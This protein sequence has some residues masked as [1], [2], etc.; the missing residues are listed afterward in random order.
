M[1]TCAHVVE[2]ALGVH[3][4]E[5]GE[6]QVAVSLP[7]AKAG[8]MSAWWASVAS[9][10]P[11][12][13]DDVVLLEPVDNPVT[14]DKK[15]VAVLGKCEGSETNK[16]QSYGFAS[17]SP[18][19]ATY[20]YGNIM[21]PVEIDQTAKINLQVKM[22]EL[23]TEDILPGLSGSGVLDTQKNL[24]VGILTERWNPK[25]RKVQPA[26]DVQAKR[27]KG[28]AVDAQ[29]LSLEPLG[30]ALHEGPY[31]LREAAVPRDVETAKAAAGRDLGVELVNAPTPLAEWVGR[32]DL[33]QK[34]TGDWVNQETRVTG[35]IGFGGEGKS[36]L[37]RRWLDDLLA[38]NSNRQ[39]DGVFWWGF[40]EKPGVDEFFEAALD[41]LGQG[42]IDPAAYPS[43]NAKARFIA[44]MLQAGRYLFV[45]DGLEVMQDQEGDDYGLL[46]NHDLADFLKYFSLPTH[47]SFC[48]I[49]SRAPVLDLMDFTTYVHRDVMRLSARDGRD[50]LSKL[51]VQGSDQE[52]D[53]V[54][55]D[56]DGHALTLSLVGSHVAERHEGDVAYAR[57]VKPYDPTE[58][59]YERVHRVL[60]RYDENLTEAERAFLKLFSAFRKPVKEEAFTKVFRTRTKATD[61]N[62]PIAALSAA[63]FQAMVD[64]LVKYRMLRHDSREQHYTAHPLIRRH[65]EALLVHGDQNQTQAAHQRIKDY[66]LD[67]AGDVPVNP[68]LDDLAPLIEVVHHACR[69]GAYDEAHEIRRD[70]IYQGNRKI[71]IHQ[72]GAYETALALM[73]EFFPGS[74]PSQEPLVTDPLDKGWLLNEVGLCLMALGSLDEAP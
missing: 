13:D 25:N 4:R 49:T 74:D 54:V 30:L 40:Y 14:L 48:L 23:R 36:S 11:D 16:F 21:G 32:D 35:L 65:Y 6:A 47:E 73:L 27:R 3:P 46:R 44:G 5:A 68:T 64:R 34:I 1:V 55:A 45:L 57:D 53:Q 33:R 38:D 51:G 22:F 43:A 72:L 63:D 69:A 18:Y 70:R 2:A 56:W 61:L 60:R 24:V 41:F 9:C 67:L 8:Q 42:L 37:A 66:Y 17:V 39:P 52:L 20:A 29:V 15:Q 58:S 26:A 71:L 31:P 50:L 59:R 19:S 62:A 12:H 7:R 10:F 28:W